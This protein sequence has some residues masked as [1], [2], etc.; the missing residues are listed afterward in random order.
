[1]GSGADRLAQLLSL[2]AAPVFAIMAGLTGLLGDGANNMLC[3]TAPSVSELGGM[4][5]M[6]TLMSAFHLAP[7]LKLISERF[8]DV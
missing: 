6:Y 5:T 1:V 7:W 3:S 8:R 2:A 4:I